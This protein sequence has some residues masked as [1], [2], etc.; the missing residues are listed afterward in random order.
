M[1]PSPGMPSDGSYGG[2]SP[3]DCVC[4]GEGWVRPE[5][6]R[7]SGQSEMPNRTNPYRDG[8]TFRKVTKRYQWL[9]KS[10]VRGHDPVASSP[11]F[12]PHPSFPMGAMRRHRPRSMS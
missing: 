11:P 5:E 6:D 7:L 3:R 8:A 12:V 2:V 9:V 1:S 4:A 10:C